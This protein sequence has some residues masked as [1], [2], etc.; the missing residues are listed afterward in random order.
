VTIGVEDGQ[1]VGVDGGLAVFATEEAEGEADEIVLIEGTD[2]NVA[3]RLAG[4]RERQRKGIFV[5]HAPDFF[6]D[7]AQTTKVVDALEVANMNLLGRGAGR[8]GRPIVYSEGV[9]S[10]QLRGIGGGRF[11]INFHMPEE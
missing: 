4:D 5:G 3:C 8:H 6:F 11:E 2:K 9:G 10:C 1:H 7:G